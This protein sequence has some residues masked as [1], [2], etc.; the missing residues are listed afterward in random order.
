MGVVVY[1]SPL[2]PAIVGA[3]LGY[4]ERHSNEVDEIASLADPKQALSAAIL[5]DSRQLPF[6]PE[7]R[8]L[9][10]A[11]L[12]AH[13]NITDQAAFVG[14]GKTFQI[15]EPK[16]LEEYNARALEMVRANLLQQQAGGAA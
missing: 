9:L 6:D 10:P 8:I 12:L 4:M 1:R 16:A 13:A 14:R 3:D 5:A 2:L 7:G 15:W 11:D